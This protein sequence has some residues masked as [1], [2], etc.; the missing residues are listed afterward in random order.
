MAFYYSNIILL[1]SK[2]SLIRTHLGSSG[3]SSCTYFPE[4]TLFHMQML[5]YILAPP[6]II[7]CNSDHEC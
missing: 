6:M 1:E 5:C 2:C 7:M 3:L 4:V